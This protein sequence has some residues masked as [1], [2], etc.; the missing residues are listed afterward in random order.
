MNVINIAILLIIAMG[1]VIGFKQ[2]G[3]KR[4]TSFVGTILVFAISWMFKDNLAT[5]L[6]EYLPFIHFK[7]DLAGLDALN[8]L[9]YEL[10]AFAIIFAFLTFIFRVLLVVTGLIEK[11]LKL[12][13]FLSIPSKIFGIFIGAI[14]A[15]FYIFIVLVILNLPIF[16]ISLIKESSVANFILKDSIILSSA[17]EN[18]V[19]T[20]DSVYDLIKNRGDLTGTQTNERIL[21]IFLD[22]NI[23]SI[24]NL[25]KLIE[26]NKIVIDDKTILDNYR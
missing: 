17:S 12:T 22:N 4:F 26:K 16:N 15:Y 3:I 24:E 7:G 1:A 20:Y 14:E 9:L 18:L 19:K 6:Y 5:F 8:I 23:I 11:L 25:D 10:I 13:I 21:I 2:G